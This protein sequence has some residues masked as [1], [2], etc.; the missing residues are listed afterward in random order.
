MGNGVGNTQDNQNQNDLVRICF[1]KVLTGQRVASGFGQ[2]HFSRLVGIS[3]SHLR[4]IEAGETSP[5]L[6]T[7][8]KIAD[9]LQVEAGWLLSQTDRTMH[10]ASSAEHE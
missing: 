3:N 7:L 2:R 5:T 10:A 1:G 6:V 9:V 4:K 8:Y